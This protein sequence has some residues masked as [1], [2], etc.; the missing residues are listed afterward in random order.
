MKRNRDSGFTLLEIIIALTI[1]LAIFLILFAALRL[2]YKAQESGTEKEEVTQT[3]RILDDRVAWLIR[4]VY[5]FVYIDPAKTDRPKLYFNGTDDEI[6]FVTTSVDSHATGPEDIGG[7]K[8]VSIFADSNGLQTREKVFFLED[9]FDDSGGK[10]SV[11]DPE[12]KN[13]RFEYYD[14]PPGE[15]EGDWVSDW[16][17]SDKKYLPAAVKVQIT[18]EHNGKTIKLPEM[19]VL[20][21]TQ[22]DLRLKT[23]GSVPAGGGPAVQ[24]AF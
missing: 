3:M 21:S 11:L 23:G 2:G 5:P 19:V 16:D 14:V 8:Y 13:I 6:G 20:I 18:F 1:S 12:V 4:G 24:Q 17:A 22:K 10:V 9:A 15:K 7:L